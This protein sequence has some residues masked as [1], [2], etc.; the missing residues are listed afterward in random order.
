[1]DSGKILVPLRHA[2]Y[3]FH[4]PLWWKSDLKLI[5]LNQGNRA[6]VINLLKFLLTSD[7][8][9]DISNAAVILAHCFLLP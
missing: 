3:A 4:L 8:N 7:I 1:M 6:K 5:L 2:T 9:W